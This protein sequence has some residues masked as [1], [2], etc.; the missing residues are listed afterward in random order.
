MKAP[1]IRHSNE[2][3]LLF[4]SAGLGLDGGGTAVVGRT[5]LRVLD[6][7]ACEVGLGVRVLN[8]GDTIPIWDGSSRSFSGVQ[9]R[10]ARAIFEAQVRE[11]VSAIVFDFLGPARVQAFLP[12][13]LRKPYLVFLHGVEVWRELG[14]QRRRAL[15]GADVLLCNSEYTCRRARQWN[16]QL[17]DVVPVG[18]ALE[19]RHPTGELEEEVLKGTGD[20]FALIV[21]RMATAE[22]YKGHDSLLLAMRT[23]VEERPSAKLVV[24]GSGDDSDRLI[25]KAE[26]LGL[27][28]N[29]FF[30]GFVSELTL[31]TLY[32]RCSF[33]VLPSRDEGFGLVYLEAMKRGKACIGVGGG[34]AEEIIESG[35][36]GLLVPYNAPV[37]LAE[38]MGRLF[39]DTALRERLGKQGLRRWQSCFLF[40]H[41]RQKTACHIRS[42]LPLAVSST[43]QWGVK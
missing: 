20:E 13:T 31:S 35:R 25:R 30:T 22:R 41:F 15:Q 32:S 7:I 38:G 14:W 37:A 19:E 28:E 26:N 24:V 17:P 4:V 40:E 16:P 29:I 11:S 21:G 5:L 43:R 1:A 12:H 8:L 18:L 3:E 9:V 39:A 2:K 23:L 33:F 42:L 27:A 10:L 6:E 36:T 34:A